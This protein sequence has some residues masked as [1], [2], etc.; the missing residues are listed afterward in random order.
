MLMLYSLLTPISQLI[1][2]TW[3]LQLVDYS[4]RI[5]WSSIFVVIASISLYGMWILMIIAIIE[6]VHTETRGVAAG[7][8]AALLAIT[9]AIVNLL[10]AILIPI[11]GL[12]FVLVV[13]L[14]L[15]FIGFPLI[16]FILPETK[17][18]DLKLIK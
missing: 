2:L 3:A 5:I 12:Y 1:T 7:I 13:F 9:G 11:W 15:M 16:A 10:T 17:G 4:S 14:S 8:K 18:R 6:L